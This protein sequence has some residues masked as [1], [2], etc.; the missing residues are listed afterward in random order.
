MPRSAAGKGRPRLTSRA[1]V[2]AV[3]I[4]AITLSLAYPVR[5][6]IAQRRQIGQLSAQQQA[7]TAQLGR[8]HAQERQLSDPAYVEQIARDELHLCMPRQTCYV[9]IDGKP[10]AGLIQP[11]TAPPSP[12]YDR[13]WQSVREADETGKA[14]KKT[15][16]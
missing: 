7:L 9:I 14:G 4:C 15:T 11:H 10:A 12:W 6:Y 5:E 13:L 16:R 2:L 1:A 3:V 8:L